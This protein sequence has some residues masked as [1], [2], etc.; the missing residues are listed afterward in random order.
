MPV[1]IP[2]THRD[3]YDTGF[4]IRR[5]VMGAAHVEHSL[6]QTSDFSRPV[7]EMITEYAWGKV[8]SRPGLDPKTRSML[9]L[10]MLTALNRP[11]EF[12]G[13]VRGAV[14]YGVTE[15][16]MQEVLL[17]TMIYCGAPAALES[18]RVAETVLKEIRHVG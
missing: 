3:S 2:G 9:N 11:H 12:A 18:F 4:S 10:A 5:T 6:G 14:A 17:Q 7:Q 15:E 13:H 8:W 16:E 1:T